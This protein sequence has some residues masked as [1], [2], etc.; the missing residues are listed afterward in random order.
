MVLDVLPA[1]MPWVP[2]RPPRDVR[3][4]SVEL[5]DALGAATDLDNTAAVD[6]LLMSGDTRPRP[7]PTPDRARR[8]SRTPTATSVPLPSP[9][10]LEPEDPAAP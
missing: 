8:S 9:A 1:T 4:F 2:Y 5:V 3:E 7:T 10:R 6:Q